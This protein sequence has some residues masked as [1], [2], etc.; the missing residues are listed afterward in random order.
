MRKNKKWSDAR[1][2]S[3]AAREEKMIGL[4]LA[5][6][7]L[8]YCLSRLVKEVEKGD[9]SEETIRKAE[10]AIFFVRSR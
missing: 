7:Q 9:I 10:D 6:E 2:M 5:S 4:K 3:D 8:L 1:N